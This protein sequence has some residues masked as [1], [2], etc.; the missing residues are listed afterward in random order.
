MSPYTRY[1]ANEGSDEC[2]EAVVLRGKHY[3]VAKI[4]RILLRRRWLILTPL[5]LGA[6]TGVL[7]YRSLPSSPT[8]TLIAGVLVGAPLGGLA[9]GLL[10]VGFLE[11]R[12]STFKCE[13]DVVQL[14]SI[15]VLALVPRMAEEDEQPARRGLASHTGAWSTRS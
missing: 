14:L 10:F 5:A 7:G 1:L 2:L 4:G 6:V 15:P 3:A 11:Y 13:E 9:L 8:E 12:D